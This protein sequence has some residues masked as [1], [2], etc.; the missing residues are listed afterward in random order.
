MKHQIDTPVYEGYLE[1]NLWW[2]ANKTSNEEKIITYKKYVNTYVIAARIEALVLL[3]NKFS[4]GCAKEVCHL[5]AQQ[6]FGTFH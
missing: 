2:A 6:R 5:W 1:S 4:Y 3:E